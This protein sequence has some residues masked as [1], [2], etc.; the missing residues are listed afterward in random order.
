[1]QLVASLFN[2]VSAY[3]VFFF[4]YFSQ[5]ELIA[6]S[7]APVYFYMP[8]YLLNDQIAPLVVQKD[9]NGINFALF[10]KCLFWSNWNRALRFVQDFYKMGSR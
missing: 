4:G 2:W 10:H 7:T 9:K 5:F 8:H 6:N 3:V 1:L